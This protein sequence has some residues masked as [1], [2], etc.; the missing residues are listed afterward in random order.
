MQFNNH[1]ICPD[2][3]LS[4]DHALLTVKISI[5]E[6]HIQTRKQTIVKNSEEEIK[7]IAD[8]IELVKRLNT[9]HISSKEDLENIVQEFAHSIDDI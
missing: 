1:I 4:S 9:N 5:L 6:E 8:I 3:R 2:W 7:F